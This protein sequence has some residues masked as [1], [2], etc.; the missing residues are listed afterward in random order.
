MAWIEH[1]HNRAIA[2]CFPRLRAALRRRNLTLQIAFVVIFQQGKKRILN[3]RRIGRVEIHHQALFERRD[4]RQGKQLRL[5]VLLQFKHHA[6]G[7]RIELPDAR[8][9]NKRIVA[10]DLRRHPFQHGVEVNAFEIHHHT[11]RV[12][13][14]KLLIFQHAIGF[15]RHARIGRRWPDAHRHD[16]TGGGKTDLTDAK[17]PHCPGPF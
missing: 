16:L 4:R 8:R 10:A 9:F 2:P 7:L 15:D 1:D 5:H 14:G 11:F 6:H 3:I 17:Q 13:E 12:A